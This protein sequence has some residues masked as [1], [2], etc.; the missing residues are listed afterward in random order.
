LNYSHT[1][2]VLLSLS[3]LILYP[4]TS[5]VYSQTSSSNQNNIKEISSPG[6]DNFGSLSR[7]LVEEDNKHDESD[8]DDKVSS[9]SHNKAKNNKR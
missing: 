2:I 8:D 3:I 1:S 9:N 5:Q 6:K 7:N 4:F